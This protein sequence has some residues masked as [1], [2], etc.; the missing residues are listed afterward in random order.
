MKRMTRLVAGATSA[1]VL[2]G[3]ATVLTGSAALAAGSL[4]KITLNPSSGLD[5][6]R[7]S[8]TTAAGCEAAA[9]YVRAILNGPSGS[10]WTGQVVLGSTDA[11]SLPALN[12]STGFTTQLADTWA[13]L[14]GS[15]PGTSYVAGKYVVT[16]Q[17]LDST[18]TPTGTTGVANVI[19][20]TPTHYSAQVFPA[21]T[22]AVTATPGSS[23][24]G[25]AVSL[26]ATVTSATAGTIPGAVQF[27]YVNGAA[28]PVNLGAPVAL[29]SG[30]ASTSVSNLPNGTNTITATFV[31]NND[32][33]AVNQYQGSSGTTTATVSAPS[34]TTT[35][36]INPAGPKYTSTPITLASTVVGNA[37]N[38]TPGGSVV[39]T[40]TLPGATTATVSAPVTVASDGTASLSLGTLS[41]GTLTATCAFTPAAGSPYTGSSASQQTASIQGQDPNTVGTEFITTTVNAGALTLAVQGFTPPSPKTA[42]GTPVNS[43]AAYPY[44][45]GAQPTNVVILPAAN[46][47]PTG[48]FIETAGNIIP[49]VVTDTRA[50]DPGYNVTGQLTQF[51]GTV[52]THKINAAD[53]GWTP[54]FISF[55]RRPGVTTATAAGLTD[56]GTALPADG[57]LP[58][59]TPATGA[60]DGLL[61]SKTLYTAPA[62]GGTGTVTYGA[63]VS[64]KAPTTTLP[65]TYTA[66]LTLTANGNPVPA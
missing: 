12:S 41:A 8:F 15:N 47:N 65:D 2:A 35:L 10:G 52:S 28:A 24:S 48:T 57:L 54:A 21:T 62:A 55:N 38:G 26:A 56:G 30:S 61:S 49:V 13:G 37:T 42:T 5:T 1:F 4:G 64:L 63:R 6:Q 16:F 39:F 46:V 17:C 20:D 18:A 51:V 58:S 45:P 32:P 31:A 59:A 7:P 40:Y 14:K 27:S 60:P 23:T 33:N 43:P 44:T 3:T 29:S 11:T 36:A 9:T 53:L 19:F 22:T 50:G 25:T 34:S 66:T